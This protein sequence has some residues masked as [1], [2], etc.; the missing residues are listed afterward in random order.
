MGV[1]VSAYLFVGVLEKDFPTEATKKLTESAVLWEGYEVDEDTDFREWLECVKEIPGLSFELSVTA[2]SEYSSNPTTVVGFVI[3]SASGVE[4]EDAE[5]IITD[6][7]NATQ[8]FEAF[9]G[10]PPKTFL[11]P[12]WW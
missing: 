4:E 9:F 1:D 2:N 11:F 7:R 5:Q 8:E 6:L 12:R 10:I 3:C